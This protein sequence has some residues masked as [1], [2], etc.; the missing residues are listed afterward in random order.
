[1]YSTSKNS[2]YIPLYGALGLRG[3]KSRFKE[4]T[5]E[6]LEN[7]TNTYLSNGGTITQIQISDTISEFTEPCE[8]VRFLNSDIT[9]F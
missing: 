7:L 4:H 9:G 5:H 2:N 3:K 8:L 6:E 1:M